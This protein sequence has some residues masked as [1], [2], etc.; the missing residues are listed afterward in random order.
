MMRSATCAALVL[1]LAAAAP[2]RAEAPETTSD[3]KCLVFSMGMSGNSDATKSAVGAMATLYFLGRLDGREPA[4]NLEKRLADPDLQ[5]KPSEAARIGM[6]CGG[7]L[8]TR[9]GELAA[10]GERLKVVGK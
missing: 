8:Q 7:M 5:L 9:G 10:M 3:L 6:T 2:A 4:L 1:A